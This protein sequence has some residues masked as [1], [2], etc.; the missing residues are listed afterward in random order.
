MIA[1]AFCAVLLMAQAAM[2]AEYCTLP[3]EQVM[4]LPAILAGDWQ[5]VMRGGI[6]VV[7]GTPAAMPTDDAPEQATFV[8]DGGD[9]TLEQDDFFPTT[10]LTHVVIAE[11]VQPDLALPGESPLNALELLD[12][13]LRETG[14]SCDPG[15]LPQFAGEVAMDGGAASTLRLYAFGPEM[16]VLV[17]KGESGHQAARAVFDL[18][19]AAR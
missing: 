8:A 1:K 12:P 4:A 17:I 6:G 19:R 2:A 16:M 15:T 11:T 3:T 5:M 18:K 7:D 10:R 14:L 13:E 9:V